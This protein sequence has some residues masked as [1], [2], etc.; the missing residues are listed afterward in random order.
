MVTDKQRHYL[1]YL[2]QASKREFNYW[3]RFRTQGNSIIFLNENN[4]E[5][6]INWDKEIEPLYDMGLIEG[7]FKLTKKGLSVII[8]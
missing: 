5:I 6:K 1:K 8:I 4:D 2:Y 3:S 7:G